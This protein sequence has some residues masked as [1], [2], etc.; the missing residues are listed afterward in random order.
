M[1]PRPSRPPATAEK[2]IS[3]APVNQVSVVTNSR[4]SNVSSQILSSS[5]SRVSSCRAA[6]S[7]GAKLPV[8]ASLLTGPLLSDAPFFLQHRPFPPP[9]RHK[10]RRSPPQQRSRQQS[11][12]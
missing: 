8:C 6:P 11:R 3:S 4:L 2:L 10:Q 9:G 7:D 12:I 5:R 1:A